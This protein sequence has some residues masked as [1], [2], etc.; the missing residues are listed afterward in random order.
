MRGHQQRAA[1]RLIRAAR[2]DS[3]QA[4]FDQIDSPDT[5]RRGNL[6]QL[7]EQCNRGKFFPADRDR[8]ACVE[9]DLDFRRLIGRFFRRGDPFPHRFFRLIRGVFEHAALM[10]QMPDVAVARVNVR[11]GLFDG[12]VMR[13]GIIDGVLARVDG[14]LAPRRDDFHSRRDGLVSQLEP[15][16]VVPLSGAAV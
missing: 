8:R 12:H 2:L 13:A 5:V 9:S 1:G 3:D 10:A 6:V 14:P 7:L 4:I 16:L 15:H 11:I